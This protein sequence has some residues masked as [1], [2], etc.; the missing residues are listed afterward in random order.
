LA[1]NGKFVVITDNI[2]SFEQMVEVADYL[3]DQSRRKDGG[4]AQKK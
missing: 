1:V 3:L 2:K 4:A